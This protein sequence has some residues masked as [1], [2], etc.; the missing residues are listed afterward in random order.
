MSEDGTEKI[1]HFDA[2]L[3]EGS[4]MDRVSIAVDPIGIIT[5][6]TQIGSD[7]E[8]QPMAVVALPG[9]V[10]VHS[11]AFQRGF[12]G[13]SEYRTST[14]DSFWTWRKLMY[15]FVLQLSP[16]D[17]YVIAKQ[18][19]LEMLAA[20]YTWVG[21]FH[22]LHNQANGN[23]Y[24]NLE[25][26]SE[27]IFRAAAETG[28]GLCHLPVLYQRAGFSGEELSDGQL[29][30]GL[31]GESFLELFS[32]CQEFALRQDSMKAGVALHS[33]RAVDAR[34][35]SEMLSTFVGE[36]IPVHI[37]VAEQTKEV[38]DCLGVTGYRPVDLLFERFEVD[39]NWCLIH[40]TH[41]S[42]KEVERIAQSGAVVGLCPTTEAN[43]GDGFFQA[44]RYLSN[45]GKISIGSDSHCSVDLR[46]ELRTL[47]YGQRLLSRTRAVLGTD[48]RSVGRR[49]YVD[50]AR[51]GAEA[52]GISAGEIAVGQRADFTLVDP[53]SP[54]IAGA[55]KDRLLDRFVFTNIGNPVAGVVV[56]GRHVE[57]RSESFL[58]AYAES[59]R[60]FSA[61]TRRLLG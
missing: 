3:V 59:T 35:A 22:Y 8:A 47:E 15:E 20:G 11:H 33:L 6:I 28:I 25:M 49:L 19:Y 51:G 61:L 32:Q 29:R 30:F 45:Q 54:A 23:S 41:L 57:T 24:D 50:C 5:E 2:A 34:V 56:G 58:N 18:L 42:E 4:W 39:A 14:R 21:E 17:V 55:E 48:D 16:D 60:R 38:D 46:D 1:F 40:A 43:L 52:L 26:M 36:G 10:N 27:S 13:L 12:V 53:N 9:M 44:G 37:H 7:V 31:S